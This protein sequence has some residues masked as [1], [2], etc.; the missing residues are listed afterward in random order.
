[1]WVPRAG[2]TEMVQVESAA[3]M[4]AMQEA[5]QEA[6]QAAVQPFG[7]DLLD[8]SVLART[9]SV[10]K[11]RRKRKIS[12]EKKKSMHKRKLKIQLSTFRCVPKQ[13]VL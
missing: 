8:N 5:E 9:A 11:R 12:F 4:A 3:K 2:C 10:I 13:I 7:Q 1:M 6:G